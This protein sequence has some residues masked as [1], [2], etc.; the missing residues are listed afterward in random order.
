[1]RLLEQMELQ[2]QHLE[3]A[4]TEDELAADEAADRTQTVQSF[5]RTRPSRKPFPEHLPRERTVIPAPERCPATARR[6]WR[7][8][9]RTS[10]RRWR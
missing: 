2:L 7:S 9:A 10:L 3:V 6:S 8:S 1:M 4:A 5:Q